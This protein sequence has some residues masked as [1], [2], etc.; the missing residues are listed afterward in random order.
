MVNETSKEQV[1]ETVC[2]VVHTTVAFVDHEFVRF[3]GSY[4][5]IFLDDHNF[6]VGDKVK[7]TFQK[8]T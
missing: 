7:I 3:E 2:Y 6:A 5:S 4:E 8:E 1:A